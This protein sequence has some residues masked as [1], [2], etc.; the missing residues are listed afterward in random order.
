[1]LQAQLLKKR[2]PSGR[3]E[4]VTRD[5][6]AEKQEPLGQPRTFEAGV[7]GQQNALGSKAVEQH[8]Q[9]SESASA[10]VVAGVAGP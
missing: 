2:G 5:I 10:R 7:P 1:M 4:R 9:I 3:G 6:S 8:D